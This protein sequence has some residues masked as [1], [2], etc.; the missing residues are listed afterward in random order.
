MLKTI[1]HFSAISFVTLKELACEPVCVIMTILCSILIGIVPMTIMHNFGEEGK[2]ARDG[3]L[4]FH[5]LFGLAISVSAASQA[6]HSDISRGTAAS[7]L[8]KPISRTLFLLTKFTGV[9]LLLGIFSASVT[10]SSL[11]AERISEKTIYTNNMV[12]TTVDYGTAIRLISVNFIA[13]LWG[14]IQHWRHGR[15]GPSVIF[16]QPLLLVAAAI[17]G[18]FISRTGTLC[19]FSHGLDLRLIPVSALIL[20]ALIVITAIST[21]L[22]IS[23]KTAPTL[24]LTLV[25][26][27][28]GLLMDACISRHGITAI[29][30][31]TLIPD[32]QHFWQCDRLSRG[33]TVG[34]RQILDAA[35]YAVTYSAAVLTIGVTVIKQRDVSL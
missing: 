33:G 25:I 27:F 19:S 18:S 7:L 34:K 16:S 11:L 6:V 4:A 14:G 22:S 21:T 15:F 10:V 20:L 8:S 23:L 28:A 5:L 3:A 17:T 26:L 13:L 35:I 29:S 1:R 24:I 30:I 9:I 32:W 2:L 12:L 31:R